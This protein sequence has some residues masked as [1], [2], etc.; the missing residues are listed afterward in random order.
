MKLRWAALMAVLALGVLVPATATA[1]AA[2]PTPPPAQTPAEPRS[3]EF[4]LGQNSP[5]PFGSATVIPFQ[6]GN[7]ED[8][9]DSVRQYHVTLRIYN[10]LAQLVAIPI[11]QSG[12]F[13]SGQSIVNLSMRCGSYTAF[14]NRMY[15]N[16]SQ[17][18]LPGVY[19]YRFEVDGRAVARK[20]VIVR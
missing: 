10:V 11:L 5:N 6:L 18:V 12:E 16:T 4:T 7:P 19:L 3:P 13:A 15:L 8:C 17:P 2:L 9:R 1:Q 20:M 14:W